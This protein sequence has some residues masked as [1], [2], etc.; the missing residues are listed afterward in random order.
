MSR[1]NKILEATRLDIGVTNEDNQV[2]AKKLAKEF[3][4]DNYIE[5]LDEAVANIAVNFCDSNDID[6]P[7][8]HMA[9]AGELTSILHNAFEDEHA[10]RLAIEN[11]LDA[12]DEEEG[13]DTDEAKT[14]QEYDDEETDQIVNLV[15]EQ[16]KLLQAINKSL[17]KALDD[18][19]EY[20]NWLGDNGVEALLSQN[21][22]KIAQEI[23]NKLEEIQGIV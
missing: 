9:L 18:A 22:T 4:S 20:S 10:L 2:L 3:I 8:A 21:N 16:H 15:S 5:E 23:S 1:I 12:N 19:N 11:A 6:S 17:Q 14:H 13:D 7:E